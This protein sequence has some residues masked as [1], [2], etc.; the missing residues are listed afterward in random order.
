MITDG[1]YQPEEFTSS[2]GEH[3]TGDAVDTSTLVYSSTSETY[4]R[5]YVNGTVITFNSTG[6]ETSVA[7]RNGNTYSF[8]YLTS[9]P[10]AGALHT[11]TGPD[12]TITTLSFDSY[13]HLSSI[14]DPAGRVTTATIG[15][16]TD[17][18][19]QLEDPSTAVRQYGYNSNHE[20]T[21]EISANGATA[22]IT[23]DS[24][25]RMSSESLF[26][27]TGTVTIEPAQEVGL[28]SPGQ[29]H[30]AGALPQYKGI[31]TDPTARPPPLSSTTWEASSPSSTAV[32]HITTIVRN[33]ND[34][35]ADGG[36]ARRQPDH[37][38]LRFVGRRHHRSRWPAG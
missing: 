29:H 30:A 28:A 34:W 11:V 33:S 4:T 18:L 14:T 5:T 36:G 26:G 9:G 15:S 37:L 20:M 19:T 32:A 38:R 24:F 10:A 8:A 2:D 27:A 35:A 13:G 31:A 17:N 3:Y 12:G 22:T 16:S 21:T 7:D 1:S 25:N 6:Q 23:Y